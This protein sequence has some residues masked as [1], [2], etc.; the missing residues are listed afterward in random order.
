VGA[1]GD[2]R[3]PADLVDR[4]GLVGVVGEEP[5]DLRHADRV[6]N[7]CRVADRVAVRIP[8][9]H[10]YDRV[11]QRAELVDLVEEVGL[12]PRQRPGVGDAMRRADP[13]DLQ[14]VNG[15]SAVGSPGRLRRSGGEQRV[16]CFDLGRGR[17]APECGVQK[18]GV[19]D[20][21]CSGI[22]GHVLAEDLFGLL[23][24]ARRCPAPGIA[25]EALGLRLAGDL[26]QEG[27]VAR[28][29]GSAANLSC[30]RPDTRWAAKLD[31]ESSTGIRSGVSPS[32]WAI[33]HPAE[34]LAGPGTKNLAPVS[35]S[36]PGGVARLSGLRG[37][38][39]AGYGSGHCCRAAIRA[40][41]LWLDPRCT[42]RPPR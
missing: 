8:R 23:E 35:G 31:H 25:A 20:P 32:I 37:S 15:R 19:D 5:A 2:S 40:W 39:E 38:R 42:Q 9:L 27:N 7:T 21:D 29:T 26:R 30:R 18:V 11:R 16:I 4:P 24:D 17:A 34:P 13:V 28:H 41:T 14:Q 36:A 22:G 10:V 3:G 33:A 1:P 6:Q 12:P